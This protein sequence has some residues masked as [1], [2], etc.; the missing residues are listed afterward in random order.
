MAGLDEVTKVE[1][2]ALVP[3]KEATNEIAHAV[4][5][6]GDVGHRKNLWKK[7]FG[8]KQLSAWK[9]IEYGSGQG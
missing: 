6:Q 7:G 1:F 8:E 2:R 3:L 5:P 4:S 9:P